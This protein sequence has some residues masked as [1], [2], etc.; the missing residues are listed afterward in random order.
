VEQPGRRLIPALYADAELPP[1]LATR[2]WVDFRRAGTTGPHYEARLSQLVR[3]LQGLPSADRPVR[4][5]TVEW[6]MGAGG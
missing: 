1:F 5:G 3:A 2:L 6:P 4:G